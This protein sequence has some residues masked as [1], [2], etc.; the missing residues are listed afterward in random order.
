MS[1]EETGA[2]E[3]ASEAP[4][5]APKAPGGFNLNAAKVKE[6]TTT[7][8]GKWMHLRHPIEE[9]KLFVGEGADSEGRATD[10]EKARP[11]RVKILFAKNPQLVE[12]RRSL[13]REATMGMTDKKLTD[14][15]EEEINLAI[16]RRS[17]VEFDNVWKGDLELDAKYDEHKEIFFG[18]AEEYVIQ[19]LKFTTLTS[20]FFGVGSKG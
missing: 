7:S 4:V 13:S 17:I 20:N 9:H 10:V 15:Q 2:A 8:A 16:L 11:V 19:V 1:N 5:A 18:M 14:E 3:T 6:I 12:Y